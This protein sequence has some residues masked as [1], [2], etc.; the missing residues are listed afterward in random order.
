MIV[1][2]DYEAIRR[3]Y[4]IEKKSIRQ[5][6]REQHHSRRIIRRAIKEPQ[7]EPYQRTM[8]KPAPVFGAS[9]ARVEALVAQNNQLPKKQ[10]YT[11]RKIY[12]TIVSEGY[13]GSESS[14]RK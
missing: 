8:I 10:H 1:M 13:E 12:E 2:E 14:I 7:P 11:A 4:Y 6:A 5:I 3:A 9:R